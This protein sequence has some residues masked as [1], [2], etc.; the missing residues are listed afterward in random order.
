ML[1]RPGA[2]R[3]AL[4][5]I[6]VLAHY[7][8]LSGGRLHTPIDGAA[9]VAFFFLSGYW[10]TKLWDKTYSTL[11]SPTLTF[12][13]SRAWRIYPLAIIGTLMM[14]A[15]ASP[16]PTM[17]TVV[18]NFA[19]IGLKLGKSLNPPEWSLAIEVQ[20]Y[21]AAPFLFIALRQATV[22]WA[23]V[24]FGLLAWLAFAF[25]FAGTTLLVFVLHFALGIFYARTRRAADWMR[26]LAPISVGL[27]FFLGVLPNAF[28]PVVSGR[29]AER[30]AAVVLSISA[31]PY[32]AACLTMPSSRIDRVLGDLAYPIYLTHWPAFVFAARATPDYA[33]ALGI[34]V[35]CA[36]SVMLWALVDRPLERWRRS[37]VATA[38]GQMRLR[39]DTSAASVI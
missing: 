10:V 13:I 31:L 17:Q 38:A 27:F 9:V 6:V 33:I 8:I 19:L 29:T 11:R 28:D 35:T 2:L 24:G 21:L 1:L 20:F 14:A 22:M 18:W 4:A 16:T 7:T 12:Y 36:G 39:S 15:V 3:L 30:L 5:S 32:V 23:V 25:S 26:R 37:F 34:L